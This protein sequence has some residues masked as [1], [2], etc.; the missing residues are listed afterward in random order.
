MLCN[1]SKQLFRNTVF[2]KW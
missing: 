2:R 1:Y